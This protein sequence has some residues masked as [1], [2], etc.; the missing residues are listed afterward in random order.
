MLVDNSNNNNKIIMIDGLKICA[1]RQSET[2]RYK[3][4]DSQSAYDMVAIIS[5]HYYDVYE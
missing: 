3:G 5:Q 2:D 4:A 1:K